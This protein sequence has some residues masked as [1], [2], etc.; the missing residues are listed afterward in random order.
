MFAS[1]RTRALRQVAQGALCASLAL[2]VGGCARVELPPLEVNDGPGSA[3]GNHD[4]GMSGHE[5]GPA[6]PDAYVAPGDGDS[7][8]G[9][10]DGDQQ[11]GGD[12]GGVADSGPAQHDAGG[13]SNGNLSPDPGNASGC[14]AVAPRR[15]DPEPCGLNN[16]IACKYGRDY[17]C[18][19]TVAVWLCQGG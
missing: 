7:H 11:P 1:A 10:G 14:P 19:C 2:L 9:D 4:G 3:L 5:A 12:A 16:V 13:T 6:E 15:V 17:T 8:P 18:Y